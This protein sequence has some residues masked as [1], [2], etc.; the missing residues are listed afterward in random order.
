MVWWWQQLVASCDLVDVFDDDQRGSG[1]IGEVCVR[2]CMQCIAVSIQPLD[3]I[4]GFLA[5]FSDQVHLGSHSLPLI[6]GN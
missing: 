2:V 4:A 1:V 3:A 6:H 5:C